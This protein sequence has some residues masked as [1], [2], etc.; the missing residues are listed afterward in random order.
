MI[1]S[2]HPAAKEI[3][4][5]YKSLAFK[6]NE[7]YR[8]MVYR[9]CLIFTPQNEVQTE[10]KLTY[11]ASKFGCPFKPHVFL[12]KRYEQLPKP[13]R[14]IETYMFE[15]VVRQNSGGP[16][17]NRSSSDSSPEEDDFNMERHWKHGL[18]YIFLLS[19]AFSIK[20]YFI[21]F[22]LLYPCLAWLESCFELGIG[23]IGVDID[24]THRH[25]VGNC[26]TMRGT[27]M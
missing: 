14:I 6:S 3:L 15:P 12:K 16:N 7:N 23:V 10:R 25:L 11:L 22:Q 27:K 19:F 9:S 13:N 2:S 21:D 5:L 18:V 4:S 8:Q 24:T 1:I 20:Y 26:M 17:S